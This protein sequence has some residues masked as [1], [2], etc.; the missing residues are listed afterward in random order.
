MKKSINFLT[1]LV[2]FSVSILNAQTDYIISGQLLDRNEQPV[3]FA[4]VALL[5]F[6]DSSIIAGTVSGNTGIFHLKYNKKG[7]YIFT[8]SFIGYSA[9][10][11][12]IEL[13]GNQQIQ[14]HEILLKENQTQLDE[15]VIIKER[16]K[17]R[18]QVDKT[19]YYVNSA[20][21]S[22]SGNGI[23]IVSHVPDIQV[24]LFQNV[25]MGGSENI[26]I[27]VNGIEKDAGFL[28]RIHPGK[29][30]RVEVIHSPGA[31][32]D[33]GVSGVINVVLKKNEERGISGHINGN[34]PTAGNEVFSFPSASMEYS[35][36]RFTL[37]TSY[38]GDFSFFDIEANDRRKFPEDGNIREITREENISQKNWSHKMHFGMDYFL[39][40]K[41][42]LNIYGFLSRFS[43]NLTGTTQVN[44]LSGIS[45]EQLVNY[46]K[47][48]HDLNTSAHA[49]VYYKHSFKP[50]NELSMEAT[51]YRLN[52]ENRI[53][54][55]EP[56]SETSLLS[57][58]QPS[59]QD[60]NFR[61]NYSFPL[62][63][64]ASLRSGAE[65]KIR[66]SDDKLIPEFSHSEY[67]SAAYLSMS[68]TKNKWQLIAGIR[69]EY[70]KTISPEHEYG[71]LFALPSLHL[72]YSPDKGKSLKISY[73]KGIT[74]PY[75]FQLN[76]MVQLIDPYASREGNP[77]LKPEINQ[78]L[79]MDYGM[80]FGNSYLKTGLFYS[81]DENVIETL[82]GLKNESFLE[83]KI[84]NAGTIRK[85]G[86]TGSGS[87]KVH[88]NISVNPLFKLYRV[89]TR[90]NDAA[91]NYGVGKR[92]AINFESALSMMFIMKHDIALSF[93]LQ[94]NSRKTAIQS[95]YREDAL[96]FL[97]L[98]KK[99]FDR[100]KLGIT[101]A[102]P[103][104]KSFTYQSYD[105]R[106]KDFSQHS[107]D[108][109]RMSLFPVWVKLNY[110]FAS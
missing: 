100:I 51:W 92:Q 42:Q 108:N 64:F 81:Q 104:S 9:H 80:S 13:A 21:R 54:L 105:I 59:A 95:D 27:L 52:S 62:N 85:Y 91:R 53:S 44:V 78:S 20:L 69:A 56:D 46:N 12:I 109:I 70:L 58:N 89:H 72:K 4:N 57:K 14:L 75:A 47:E 102:I 39:N 49:S 97:S 2:S 67:S 55:Q 88:K 74:R 30:D 5:S 43:N 18:Q 60:I 103:F 61:L 110:S 93:S 101:S 6:Q 68:F 79:K 40:D 99:F 37:Y 24:D 38:N 45:P 32:Y 23:D 35:R 8:A 71:E 82:T 96:Y 17:A 15:V 41:N 90:A 28:S 3:K 7:R 84:Q 48:D 66:Y 87:I 86:I 19:T 73:N 83:K 25:S 33:A 50:E 65:Q 31:E 16:V 34:V 77:E 26:I 22:T 10:Q 1:L 11:E 106:G 29:I 107:V 76:P 94:Y 63:K 98:E 36:D